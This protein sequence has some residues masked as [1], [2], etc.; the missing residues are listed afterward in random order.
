MVANQAFTEY[1]GDMTE[2]YV[3]QEMTSHTVS[4][5]YYYTADDSRLELDFVISRHA[6]LL[7]IKVKAE[8]YVRANSPAS[9]CTTFYN[10]PSGKKYNLLHLSNISFAM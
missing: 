7:P 4:P 2:Q 5:I 8:G 6:K 3:L 9:L 1:K 10:T